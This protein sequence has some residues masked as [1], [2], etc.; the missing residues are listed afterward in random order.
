MDKALL[1]QA[2]ELFSREQD[3][4]PKPQGDIVNEGKIL[5]NKFDTDMTERKLFCLRPETWLNSEVVNF[6][7][8]ML[9]VHDAKMCNRFDDRKKSHFFNSFF[10]T[11]LLFTTDNKYD[12][13]QVKRWTKKFNIFHFDK[14]VFPIHE[15]NHWNL[16]CV[17]IQKKEI[18]FFDSMASP[19]TD[20]ADRNQYLRGLMQWILDEGLKNE[21]DVIETEWRL[22]LTGKRFP[23]QGNGFDCAVFAIVCA[24]YLADNL[25]F[26][27]SQ[28]H[29]QFWRHKIA[30]DILRGELKY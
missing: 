19:S 30:V 11:R 5:I 29:M 7:M 2:I 24:D 1:S 20:H 17:F 14:V 26:D 9:N 18:N 15:G 16:A 3:F 23:Q 4:S 21:H 10:F 8:D 6:Y 22:T 25:E 13:K 27:F 12:Y 28:Q